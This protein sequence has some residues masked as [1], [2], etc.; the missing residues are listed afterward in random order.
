[1]RFVYYYSMKQEPDAVR[2]VA[3]EHASYWRE[4]RL[5]RYLGGPFTD[6][7][8]GLI[9]FEAASLEEA[10]RLVAADPFV[11]EGLLIDSIVNGWTPE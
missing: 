8:G 1:M 5:G 6:R 11:T 9:T 4:G 10:E 3:P 2:V 7:S